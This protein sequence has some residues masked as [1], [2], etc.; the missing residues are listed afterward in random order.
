[1]VC[2]CIVIV[3]LFYLSGTAAADV[4][5]VGS[6]LPP[7]SISQNGELVV[8]NGTPQFRAW[9]TGQLSGRA[10]LLEYLSGHPASQGLY[11]DLNR[12][13][14]EFTSL[15]GDASLANRFGVAAIVNLDD[16]LWGTKSLVIN[17]VVDRQQLLPEATFVVDGAGDARA[18]WG[19]PKKAVALILID[20]QGVVQYYRHGALAQ[21]EI[22]GLLEKIRV[23][24]LAQ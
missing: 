14:K 15:E 2:R 8:H 22:V 18:R 23:L 9:Q 21:E 1:M 13:L 17:A 10:V 24:S 12:S 5:A 16:S 11:E 19:L 6:I 3:I 20:G 4:I 7:V